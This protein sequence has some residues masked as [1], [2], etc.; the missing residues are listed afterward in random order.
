MNSKTTTDT[1]T[2][3]DEQIRIDGRVI[4]DVE[5]IVPANKFQ[6]EEHA[7]NILKGGYYDFR[8]KGIG[9]EVDTI[10]DYEESDEDLVTDGGTE[11]TPG[12]DETRALLEDALDE[13]LVPYESRAEFAI[14]LA[15]VVRRG[16]EATDDELIDE[17]LVAA[18]LSRWRAVLTGRVVLPVTLPPD[19]AREE[20]HKASHPE[21]RSPQITV[22]ITEGMLHDID[23]QLGMIDGLQDGDRDAE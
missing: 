20:L 4:L 21:V 23:N 13:D 16:I 8:T 1:D 15:M 11:V 5:A 3:T 9:V 19:A 17:D 2:P 22:P 6:G 12:H 14:N 18:T 7:A 10:E